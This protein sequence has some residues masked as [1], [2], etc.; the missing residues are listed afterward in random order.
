MGNL[1][2]ENS[3][4]VQEHQQNSDFVNY[5]NKMQGN[6]VPDMLSCD[7]GDLRARKNGLKANETEAVPINGCLKVEYHGYLETF[8][9][10]SIS[11]WPHY[12]VTI[13]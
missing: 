5:L 6:L 2:G 13:V 7:N 3:G 9:L 8:I 11:F 1:Y 10:I 4:V 12:G